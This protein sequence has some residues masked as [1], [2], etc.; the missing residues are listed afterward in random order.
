MAAAPPPVISLS[1]PTAHPNAAE[2]AVITA[3]APTAPANTLARDCVI[4]ITAA[5]KNVLS[6]ISFAPIMTADLTKPSEKAPPGAIAARRAARGARRPRPTPTPSPPPAL[7][8][9]RPPLPASTPASLPLM[10]FPIII[11]KKFLG[12]IK[13][14]TSFRISWE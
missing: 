8:P 7:N 11:C 2:S 13:I 6:P 4:A 14:Y 10:K 1:S 9:S 12:Y 3:S 5:M